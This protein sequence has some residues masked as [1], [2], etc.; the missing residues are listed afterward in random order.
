VDAE[1]SAGAAQDM[2]KMDFEP[3]PKQREAIESP[4]G[5]A[6]VLAGPGAGKTFCLIQRVAYLIEAKELAPERICAVTFTNKA[7]EEVTARLHRLLGAGADRI[8]RGTLHALCLGILR[9]HPQEAGLRRGFGVADEEYQQLLLR[10]L[11]VF[12]Q[13]SRATCHCSARRTSSTSTI[14][15]R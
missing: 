11:R 4:L 10:R 9:D 12:P 2:E 7:A 8:T 13:C 1:E 6:L 15:S 14:S 5:P 3:F